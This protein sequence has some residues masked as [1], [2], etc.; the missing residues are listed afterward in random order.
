MTVAVYYEQ[1]VLCCKLIWNVVCSM[2]ENIPLVVLLVFCSE[3]DNAPDALRM[4]EYA[5]G[6]LNIHSNQQVMY[7]AD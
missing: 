3:G 6:W 2:K 4:A 1:P 5:N 7:Q